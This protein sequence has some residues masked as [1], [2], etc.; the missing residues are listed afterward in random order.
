M[1]RG[2]DHAVEK[3]EGG[4]N[5]ETVRGVRKPATNPIAQALEKAGQ[6]AGEAEGL[7]VVDGETRPCVPGAATITHAPPEKRWWL[8]QCQAA[9][10]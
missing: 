2:C 6:A 9:H 5:I 7:S 8:V 1:M 4:R 3:E 10:P